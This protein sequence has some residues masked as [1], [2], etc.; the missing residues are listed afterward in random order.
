[1]D[2]ARIV[3]KSNYEKRGDLVLRSYIRAIKKLK[4]NALLCNDLTSDI[5]KAYIYGEIKDDGKFYELFSNRVIDCDNYEMVPDEEISF[6]RGIPLSK[7]YKIKKVI[8]YVLFNRKLEFDFEVSSAEELAED[9]AV[10]FRA[11]NSLLSG[12]NP[13]PRLGENDNKAI[14][15]AY[16]NLQY[17]LKMIKKM[18]EIDQS[19]IEHDQYEVR[20]YYA[21][22]N[23]Y[24]EDDE[25]LGG[26]QFVKK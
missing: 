7:I 24:R 17:K 13:Y 5:E 14:N 11:Y 10:E 12:I 9:R 4:V 23:T 1:M 20:E 26:I 16:N 2:Y 22:D 25:S 3:I 21:N 18:K 6:F 19:V 8:E 15:N